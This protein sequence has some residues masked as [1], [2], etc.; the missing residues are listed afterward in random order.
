MVVN[1]VLYRARVGTYCG[2]LTTTKLAVKSLVVTIHTTRL[3][4]KK[5]SHVLPKRYIYVFYMNLSTN[6]DFSLYIINWLIF[7]T[8]AMCVYCAVRTECL[9]MF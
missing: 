6:N 9:N 7:I 2:T 3:I 4:N 1:M 8:Q 5:K